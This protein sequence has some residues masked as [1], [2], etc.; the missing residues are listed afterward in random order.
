MLENKKL[1]KHRLRTH[2]Y[3]HSTHDVDVLTKGHTGTG[4]Y[5]R[6]YENTFSTGDLHPIFLGIFSFYSALIS[7]QEKSR[8][9]YISLS[10]SYCKTCGNR[11]SLVHLKNSWTYK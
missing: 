2:H 4:V 8:N 11:Q 1:E 3:N 10:N 9:K 6:T 5:V 7:Y